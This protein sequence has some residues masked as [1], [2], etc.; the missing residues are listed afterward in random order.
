[1]HAD[2]HSA[3]LSRRVSI[4]RFVDEELEAEKC[5]TSFE[6][7]QYSGHVLARFLMSHLADS[8]KRLVR[9]WRE[10][11]GKDLDRADRMAVDAERRAAAAAKGSKSSSKGKKQSQSQQRQGKTEK[12]QRKRKAE[13]KG[14]AEG[15]SSSKATK[16]EEP[17]YSSSGR[18]LKR[19]KV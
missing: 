12:T 7:S 18:A 10:E 15:T 16:V 8:Q 6:W 14:A 1:M 19:V 11:K 2:P 9:R 5:A 4:R 13:S 17:A 3:D